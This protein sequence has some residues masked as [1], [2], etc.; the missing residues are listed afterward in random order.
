MGDLYGPRTVKPSSL[1]FIDACAGN[2]TADVALP[3]RP[4]RCVVRGA[5]VWAI[6]Y[7]GHRLY[8]VD[9]RLHRLVGT[10]KLSF[11][12]TG[13]AADSEGVW[14]RGN[15]ALVLV[16]PS[17]A[18]VIRSIV[19]P[20]SAGRA[21]FTFYSSVASDQGS[22]WVANRLGIARIDPR[23]KKVVADNQ[24][25]AGYPTA[26]AGGLG[27]MWVV[28][29]GGY[30]YRLD[31]L[32]AAVLKQT[33]INEANADVT[34]TALVPAA[35]AVGA[36]AVWVTDA[37]GNKAW[38]VDATGAVTGSVEAG[39]FPVAIAPA[40]GSVWVAAQ[41]DNAVS[42]IEP[43][44]ATRV[45]TIAISHTPVALCGDATQLVVAVQ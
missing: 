32:N 28:D 33:T 13:V 17:S 26:L 27:A 38:K 3:G 43:G 39:R 24:K 7:Q 15:A 34:N 18:R 20:A 35:V 40:G 5:T 44:R 9:A 31:P 11:A 1:A 37:S 29:T 25:L 36:D 2:V 42:Q 14:V 21:T 12:P 45:R 30:L 10:V 19:A 4:L 6:D 16:D 22:L 41:N 23:T 8:R